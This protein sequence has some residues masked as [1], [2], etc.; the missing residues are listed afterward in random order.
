M[1][2]AKRG[3]V[4]F[5]L[6]ETDELLIKNELS[7]PKFIR[8]LYTRWVGLLNGMFAGEVEW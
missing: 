7:G 6:Q 8:D 1:W 2:G 4:T 3:V 5:M